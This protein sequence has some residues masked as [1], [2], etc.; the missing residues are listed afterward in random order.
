MSAS[1]TAFTFM[2]ILQL[3]AHPDSWFSR[4]ELPVHGTGLRTLK[5]ER[6]KEGACRHG[7][8]SHVM[9]FS[10]FRRVSLS[11]SYGPSSRTEVPVLGAGSSCHRDRVTQGKRVSSWCA[12]ACDVSSP[13]FGA[14]LPAR[15]MVMVCSLA[16]RSRAMVGGLRAPRTEGTT[17]SN[18]LNSV[19]L[20]PL[21]RPATRRC[22]H[23]DSGKP[24]TVSRSPC[25]SSHPRHM[26]ALW[27]ELRWG[28][29]TLI[30]YGRHNAAK[31]TP[32]MA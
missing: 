4:A 20:A 6:H 26:T 17:L 12:L 19:G 11:S 2:L 16:R 7:A 18:S 28:P 13:D 24:S 23:R 14:F 10:S 8:P 25:E 27:P 30:P 21:V 5:T 29:P 31:L 15:H 3:S 32:L 22:P 1:S 9:S